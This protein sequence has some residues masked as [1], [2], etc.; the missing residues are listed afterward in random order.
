MNIFKAIGYRFTKLRV[1]RIYTL[2]ARIKDI[3]A[4][5]EYHYRV[6]ADYAEKRRQLENDLKFLKRG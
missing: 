5:E 6:A 2:Q 4:H 3:Q 1:V